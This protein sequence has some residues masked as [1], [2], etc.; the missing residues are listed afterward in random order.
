MIEEW[1]RLESKVLH[2]FGIFRVR[3][4]LN[5]SPRTEE[6]HQHYVLE[7][8][9]WVNVIPITIEGKVV[10]IHQYRHG[11]E[12]VTVEIPGGMADGTD[13]SFAEAAWRELLEETGYKAASIVP[14]GDVAPNPAVQDNRCYSFL[15][16]GAEETAELN[17][18]SGE[19]IAV[20]EFDLKA[21]PE[22]IESGRLCHSLVIVAFY[23]L[24]LYLQKNP[25]LLR[26]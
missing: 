21:I 13:S 20:Q 16:L 2:D 7:C 1:S 5:K 23:R 24:E 12:Q 3:Q 8:P 17:L 9:P 15:A 19:D 22:L 14:L 10:L 25:D 26:S 4:D 18:D 6:V 11:I